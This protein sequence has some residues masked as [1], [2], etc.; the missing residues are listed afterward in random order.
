AY[1]TELINSVPTATH[2]LSYAKKEKKKR[3][4]RDLISASYDIASLGY[5]EDEDPE[6]LVDQAEAKIFS[7]AQRSVS[8]N[9]IKVKDMLEETFERYDMLSRHERATRGVPTGFSDLDNMLSGFQKADLILLAARPSMGK[10]ALAMDIARRVAITHKTPVG[11]FSL[12][13]SRDQLVDRLVSSQAN[14]DSWRLRTGHFSSDGADNDFVRIQD[15]MG[16]LAEA[17]IFIDDTSSQSVLQ[18]RAM[19]RRLQA[20]FGLGLVVVDYLQLIQPFNSLTSVVQQV[21]EISRSLKG[22]ARELNVPV[23]ALSQLSRAVE[24]RVPQRPRLSDLRESGCVTGDTLITRADTGE[25][26]PI[27]TL[28]ERNIQSPIPIFAIGEDYK[29]RSHQMVR[30]FSSGKK[31]IFA[32]KT[33]S[34]RT[35]KASANHP[36]RWVHFTKTTFPLYKR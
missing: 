29:L 26:I 36:W 5:N 34:G 1:L 11:V 32:L 17:P 27:K 23:L 12:E 35:I 7:I 28:A 25:R 8:H 19:A 33:R 22:L 2:V 3:I 20:N 30:V 14:V 24:Q 13:M 31:K 10:S 6:V 18:M 21:T 16:A 4:L 9:F 15:A